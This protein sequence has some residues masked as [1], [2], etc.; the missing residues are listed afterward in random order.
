MSGNLYAIVAPSG[1]GKTSLVE[2]LL[3]V[4]PKIRLSV[5]YTTRAPRSGEVNGRD[6]QFVSRVEF[7][8]LLK[9]G[10][11]LEHA[12]VYGNL[13]GTSKSWIT[14]ARAAGDDVLLEIDWQGAIQVRR[15]FPDMVDIFIMPPSF[16]ALEKRLTARGKDTADVIARRIAGARQ[17]MQ[18]V[19]EADYIVVN[20]DFTTAL[21]DLRAVVQAARLTRER[22]LK[23]HA[24]IISRLV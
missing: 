4:E 14:A 19:S 12:E 2:A 15:I 3:K 16:E 24:N 18:H 9:Q 10:E 20:D 5:S 13:Y 6:Y 23:R 21:A 8:A 7:E 17:E 1:A 22:Q 11:F